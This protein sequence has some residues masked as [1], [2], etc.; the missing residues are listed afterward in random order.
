M[1]CGD[2]YNW[3]NTKANKV[4]VRLTGEI[5]GYKSF[6]IEGTFSA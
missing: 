4:T 2:V 3:S 5:M 6:G 1:S